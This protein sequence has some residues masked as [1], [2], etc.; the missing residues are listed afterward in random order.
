M[1]TVSLLSS[2]R[3]AL[4]VCNAAS[5]FF[6]ILFGRELLVNT[7][8]QKEMS[9]TLFIIKSASAHNFDMIVFN[10]LEIVFYRLCKSSRTQFPN[11]IIIQMGPLDSVYCSQN[12]SP[13]EL[14][15]FSYLLLILSYLIFCAV[16]CLLS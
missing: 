4:T 1:L 5:F 11:F 10:S 2:I 15:Y 13:M 6:I 7:K 12:A 9:N 3:S 8:M 14:S 16:I